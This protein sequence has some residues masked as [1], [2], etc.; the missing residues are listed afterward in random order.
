MREFVAAAEDAGARFDVVVARLLGA[1]RATAARLIDAR[2]ALLNGAPAARSAR[3]EE[4][5][6]LLLPDVVH[7]VHVAPE[8]EDIDVPVVYADDD[9]AVISK[10]AGLVVHPAPGHVGGT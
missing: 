2:A 8:H 5:A 1:S 10:P 9:I 6:R 7:A 3:V 4:G